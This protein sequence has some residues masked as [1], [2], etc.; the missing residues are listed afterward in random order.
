MK[1]LLALLVLLAAGSVSAEK[2]PPAPPATNRVENTGT[3][4]V[5]EDTSDKTDAWTG[6]TRKNKKKN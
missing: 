6:A 2:K 1:T 4:R 3:S 5:K